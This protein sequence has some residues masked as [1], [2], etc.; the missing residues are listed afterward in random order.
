MKDR[1][2]LMER[3]GIEPVHLLEYRR[4]EYTLHD[5][6]QACFGFGDVVLAFRYLPLPMWQLSR[7]EVGVAALALDRV[8]WLFV[9]RNDYVAELRE[10]FPGRPVFVVQQQGG[11]FCM[12]SKRVNDW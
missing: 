9:T 3:F 10:L 7:H 12:S 2:H 11:K 5:C 8:R 4:R 1:T 6:L